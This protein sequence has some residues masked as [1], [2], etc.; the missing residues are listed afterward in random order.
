MTIVIKRIYEPRAQ[1]DGTRILVDRLWPRGL[2]KQK[3]PIDA[4]LK[5]IAPS[6]QL[7][8]WFGHDPAKWKEFQHR[9]KAELDANPKAVAELKGYHGKLTLLYGARDEAHNHALVLKN[10]LEQ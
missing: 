7:R 8:A 5:D 4:W 10:Y 3:A 9:Y 2:S 1:D 6:A